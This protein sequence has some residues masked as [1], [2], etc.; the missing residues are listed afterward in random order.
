[1]HEAGLCLVQE[2]GIYHLAQ[3]LLCP[4]VHFGFFCSQRNF[5]YWRNL[6][7]LQLFDFQ[8]QLFIYELLLLKLF[9]DLLHE[10][11]E[12]TLSLFLLIN[13]AFDAIVAFLLGSYVKTAAFAAFD[14]G[15]WTRI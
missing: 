13:Q 14:L 12:F 5:I 9:L 15:L 1:M 11:Q 4:S 7:L 3:A 8:C 10:F 2:T 6:L